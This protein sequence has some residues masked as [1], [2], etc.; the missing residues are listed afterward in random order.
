[1]RI[2]HIATAQDW[3]TAQRTGTYTTSTYGRSLAEV[4][5][6]HASRREQWEA[7]RELLYA[8]VAEPLV[9][10]EIDPDLLTSPWRED[11]V[12]GDTFP[13]VYGPLDVA[14]VVAVHPL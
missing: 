8:D 7:V 4:G 9:L 3:A 5:F 6:I 12:D 13:H 14:A 10:L 11:P 2:F 1:M